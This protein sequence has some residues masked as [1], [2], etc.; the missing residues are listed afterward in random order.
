MV[1]I[2]R[3]KI[4]SQLGDYLKNIED[5]YLFA[6]MKQ[7][8]FHNAWFT[9][10]NQKSALLSIVENFLQEDKLQL[11]AK[12]YTLQEPIVQKTIGLVFAG[13]IPLVGFQDWL[14]VFV[15]GH[16]AQIKLSEKDRFMF[17]HLLKIMSQWN[18]EILEYI[19]I[20]LIMKKFDAVIAT[21][22]NNTARYFEAYFGKYPNIIRK[23]RNSVAVLMGNESK[24]DL[25]L[26]GNDIFKYF[27][28]GCRNVSKL[29]I[30]KNYDFQF[31]LETLH[32]FKSIVLH[33]KYKNNFDYNYALYILNKTKFQA[34]G[35]LLMTESASL[36]SRIANLHYEFYEDVDALGDHLAD[37]KDSIQCVVSKSQ[38]KNI[39]TIY[40]G[41]TQ[42]PSLSDYADG[43]DVM[44]FLRNL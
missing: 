23:N 2:E 4:L 32:E 17:P 14:C 6:V 33:S 30:P 37:I 7:T 12:K 39:N 27:G 18:V 21:G 43:V 34:N 26:L 24:K 25:L 9:L 41:Q 1:I 29:Y 13:N 11:W 15:A 8:E 3:I 44:N 36:Q 20:Q 31:L 28:L 22:S 35:C 38:I 19:D 5:E 42:Q 10:E 16:K 40:F